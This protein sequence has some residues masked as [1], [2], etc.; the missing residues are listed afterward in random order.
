MEIIVTPD[1]YH[2]GQLSQEHLAGA[3]AAILDQGFVIL[4]GAVA[5][6]PLDAL[7][8]C[9]TEDSQTLIA[10]RTKWGGP[11]SIK[12]HLEHGAPPF[13][14]YVFRDVVANP[15]AIQVTGAIL[16]EGAYN[17]WYS[18]NA[19]TPG[20][21]RQPLHRDGLP[22]WQD[23]PVAHPPSSLVVN[24]ALVDVSEENGSTELWPGSHLE[25]SVP[26]QATKSLVD[27][28]TEAKRRERVPP[29]RANTSKG[30]LLIRDIR[31]WHRGTPNRSNAVRHMLGM[32]HDVEWLGL[33]S[34]PLLFNTGCEGEFVGSDRF[35]HNV[36]FVDEP[37]EYLTT[38][39]PTRVSELRTG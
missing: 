15:L 2:R 29:I 20:S 26:I 36:V 5:P 4:A 31:L 32:I 9:M 12:G 1:E 37:L 8:E 21:E 3:V 10:A 17:S 22:L 35:D 6:E 24:I 18:G 11:G 23:L 34:D 16:G 19:N 7:L 13:A 25:T 28:D 39:K 33:R 30:S 27:A 14:P 38:R